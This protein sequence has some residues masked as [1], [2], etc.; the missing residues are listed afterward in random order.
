MIYLDESI[1][2]EQCWWFS[3]LLF[4]FFCFFVVVFLLVY[5]IREILKSSTNGCVGN[6][7]VHG[8]V[9]TKIYDT[10]CILAAEQ[11]ITGFPSG[12]VH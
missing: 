2:S 1:K 7:R 10:I 3:L 9:S 8:R 12:H 11:S 4:C 5:S 6:S